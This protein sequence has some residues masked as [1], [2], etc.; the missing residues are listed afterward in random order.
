MTAIDRLESAGKIITEAKVLK[1]DT[2]SSTGCLSKAWYFIKG[3]RYLV[4]GNSF[5]GSNVYYEPYS[6]VLASC[7]ADCLGISHVTYTLG[8][9]KDFPGVEVNGIR[10]VSVCEEIQLG[11]GEQLVSFNSLLLRSGRYMSF[12]DFMS[13]YR[14]LGLPDEDIY[15]MLVFDATI[16][17][18]D[19]H[20]NNWDYIISEDRLRPA[21]LLDHGASFRAKVA[22]C[23]LGV[24]GLFYPD[25]AKS[26]GN[27]H[28]EIIQSIREEYSGELFEVDF[29]ELSEAF[30]LCL[31]RVGA[32]LSAKRVKEISEYFDARVDE[33]L[34]P[35]ARERRKER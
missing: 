18:P 23:D 7:V 15:R 5:D 22:E 1:R 26:F 29:G 24:G 10:H 33:Y 9:A 25:G 31:E 32:F 27:T 34:L 30:N 16:G 2:S 19:R 8:D 20:L 6:E 21:P 11:L 12:H 35:F 13:A 17:N 4:K 28:M 14:L 3:K